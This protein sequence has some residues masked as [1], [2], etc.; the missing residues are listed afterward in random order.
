MPY[1]NPATNGKDIAIDFKLRNAASAVVTLSDMNGRQVQTIANGM[2]RSG[3][4]TV[5]FKPQGLKAG[6]YLVTVRTAEGYS[7]GKVVIE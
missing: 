5:S 4:N 6:M 2:F 7:T 1:P 3:E